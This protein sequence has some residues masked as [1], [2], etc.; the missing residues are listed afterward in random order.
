MTRH[1]ANTIIGTIKSVF[2]KDGTTKAR[3]VAIVVSAIAQ[4]GSQSYKEVVT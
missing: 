1:K 2:S 3:C 4:P